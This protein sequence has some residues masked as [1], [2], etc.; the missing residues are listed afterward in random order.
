MT[1]SELLQEIQLVHA[2][3]KIMEGNKPLDKP[4]EEIPT[5]A[6]T[7][8]QAFKKNEVICLIC[9][10]GGFKT[11]TRH[12]KVAHDL[13]PGQYRKHFNIPKTQKLAAK[14]F[15]EKM[16]IA[17]AGRGMTDILAKAREKRMANM[18]SKNVPA[19]KVKAPAPVVRKKAGVPAKVI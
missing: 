6:L 9:N 8:K 4:Q 10:K 15:S 18:A 16:V 11:L 13:K 3:L 7:L 17:A 19:V 2:T 1:Q 12:L 14:S 5:P